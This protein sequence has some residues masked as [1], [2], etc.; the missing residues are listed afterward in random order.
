MSL[1]EDRARRAE[2]RAMER[3]TRIEQAAHCRSNC[4]ANWQE[5]RRRLDR[6][7]A[8][9][10]Q[11]LSGGPATAPEPTPLDRVF[12]EQALSE[13]K[14]GVVESC[15]YNLR[16]LVQQVM[17][18]EL[19]E[20]DDALSR[21]LQRLRGVSQEL[22]DFFRQASPSGPILGE[23][24]PD[25]AR[26]LSIAVTDLLR[27]AEGDSSALAEVPGR[28]DQAL[29]ILAAAA[30][31]LR[32]QRISLHGIV[33][34]AVA[35]ERPRLTE[36]SM[37]VVLDSRAEEDHLHADREA[38]LGAL[39]ELLR[40]AAAHRAESGPGEVGIG[41]VSQDRALVLTVWSRPALSPPASVDVLFEPGRT[42]KERVG[43]DGL[44]AVRKVVRQHGGSARLEFEDLEKVFRVLLEFPRGFPE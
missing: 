10:Q 27:A 5:L 19:P 16:L 34:E 22:T 44:F 17:L 20:D 7:R 3:M 26:D 43:G 14:H 24:L 30:A 8:D 28:I 11:R 15:F 42:R 18:E 9:F 40:N 35:L 41:L 21:N 39:V 23:L 29:G 33:E 2:E 6:T 1:P 13:L 25:C 4:S 12:L 37:K 38:I 36:A 31:D 32:Q